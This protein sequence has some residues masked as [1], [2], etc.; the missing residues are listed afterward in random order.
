[1]QNVFTT[2]ELPKAAFD[3]NV[4]KKSTDTAGDGG[5]ELPPFAQDHLGFD[6]NELLLCNLGDSNDNWALVSVFNYFK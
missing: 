4:V 2:R 1:M 5:V 6:I 3:E